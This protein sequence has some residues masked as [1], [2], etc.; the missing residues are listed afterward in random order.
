MEEMT[1]ILLEDKGVNIDN[2]KDTTIRH[3]IDTAEASI[4]NYKCVDEIPDN[5]KF[6][7][8]ELASFLY[9]NNDTSVGIPNHI[10]DALGLPRVRIVG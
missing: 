6:L 1:K 10:K 9:T 7:I 8:P 3:Y 2:I 4:K 5:L